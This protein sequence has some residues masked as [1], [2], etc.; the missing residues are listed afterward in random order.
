MAAGSGTFEKYIRL[1]KEQDSVK[2]DSVQVRERESGC[3]GV[4]EGWE[5]SKGRWRVTYFPDVA[6]ARGNF[7]TRVFP[8]IYVQP[9]RRLTVPLAFYGYYRPDAER[10]GATLHELSSDNCL[11]LSAARRCTRNSKGEPG[12]ENDDNTRMISVGRHERRATF[13]DTGHYAKLILHCITFKLYAKVRR[14]E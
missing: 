5:Q 8:K 6:S 11:V 7:A 12:Y 4:R 2:D 13:R 10:R 9:C 3:T 1:Q 14:N